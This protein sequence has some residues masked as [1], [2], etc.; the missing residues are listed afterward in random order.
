MVDML[1]SVEHEPDLEV[2]VAMSLSEVFIFDED[3]VGVVTG[4]L[5]AIDGV[6]R[7]DLSLEFLANPGSS[8]RQLDD[9]FDPWRS[10][11]SSAIVVGEKTVSRSKTLRK[12]VLDFFLQKFF[13]CP[14]NR[15]KKMSSRC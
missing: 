9:A 11:L 6:L 8:S 5:L 10:F 2:R 15:T 4:I 14:E 3:V 1:E 12:K 13:L 7:T